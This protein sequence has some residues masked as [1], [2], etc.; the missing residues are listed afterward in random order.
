MGNFGVRAVD[1]Y[2]IQY[3]VFL[4]DCSAPAEHPRS[5]RAAP[6]QHPPTEF[7][8]HPRLHPW[9]FEST[10]ITHTRAQ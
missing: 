9:D 10:G 7:L 1:L 6:T 5:T 4:L 3:T 2:V 8:E